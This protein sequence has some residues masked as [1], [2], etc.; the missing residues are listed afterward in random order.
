MF[1]LHIMF[2]RSVD[3]FWL[4][5][6]RLDALYALKHRAVETPWGYDQLGYVEENLVKRIIP[7]LLL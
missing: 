5:N 6:I 2:Q 3:F 4:L 1:E 7:N